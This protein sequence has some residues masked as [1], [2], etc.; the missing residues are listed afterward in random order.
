MLHSQQDPPDP[1]LENIWI[2]KWQIKKEKKLIKKI[3]D[4]AIRQGKLSLSLV[5]HSAEAQ[6][7][8][9]MHNL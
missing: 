8:A 7:L 6:C 1:A 3:A 9:L 5:L 2:K 4:K